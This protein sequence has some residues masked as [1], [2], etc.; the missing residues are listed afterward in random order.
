MRQISKDIETNVRKYLIDG[1][2]CRQITQLINISHSTVNRIAKRS[3]LTLKKSKGGR[4]SKLSNRD[5]AYC[6]HQI[7]RGS[8]EN[9]KEVRDNVHEDLGMVISVSTV[10]RVLHEAGLYSFVQPK[11]PSLSLKNVKLRLQWAKVHVNW[12]MDDWKRVIWSDETKIER[13]GSS[14]KQY[15][16]KKP[17]ERLKPKHVKQTVKNSPGL[18]VWSCIVYGHGVGWLTKIEGNMD[19]TLYIQILDEDLQMT[20]EDYGL[21][22]SKF[23][24]MQDND[25]KHKSRMTMDYLKNQDY[26]LMEWPPQS[27]DLNPIENMWSLLKRRLYNNYDCPPKGMLEL[28]ERIGK[29]WYDISM[30]ECNKCIE[31]MPMRCRDVIKNKGYWIDY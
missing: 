23:I 29:T 6:V 28:W 8:C 12:T 27:P 24:L 21:D 19:S 13:F 25:P 10:R 2:S 9:A 16:W 14:G 22:K 5:K 15:G 11:K 26:Q 17:G 30:E 20:M 1:L 31:T 18:M 3:K 7:T 4:P